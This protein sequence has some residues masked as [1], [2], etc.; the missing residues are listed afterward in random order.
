MPA[1]IITDAEAGDGK[2]TFMIRDTEESKPYEVVVKIPVLGAYSATWP[3][4]CPKSDKIVRNMA[5]WEKK[6]GKFVLKP[7]S[8]VNRRM[9]I[10]KELKKLYI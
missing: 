6:N 4:N 10:D 5:D 1:Q 7:S 2:V 3:L 9:D 8:R